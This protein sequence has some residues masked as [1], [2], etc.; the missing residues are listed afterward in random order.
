MW[1]CP[2]CKSQTPVRSF[3]CAPCWADVPQVEQLDVLHAFEHG[4]IADFLTAI[5]AA[6]AALRGAAA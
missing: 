6:V 2:G 5:T 1:A 4:R 3:F